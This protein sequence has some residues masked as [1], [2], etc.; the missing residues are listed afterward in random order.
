MRKPCAFS[1]ILALVVVVQLA[2]VAHSAPL[3]NLVL[4]CPDENAIGQ[5]FES[6][7]GY[8][9]ELPA[10]HRIVSPATFWSRASDLTRIGLG[11][12]VHDPG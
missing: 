3:A 12:R 8:V 5:D 4:D 9:Y 6:C 10:N 7:D 11:A 2:G 1:V